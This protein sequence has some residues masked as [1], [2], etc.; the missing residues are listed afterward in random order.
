MNPIKPANNAA[1]TYVPRNTTAKKAA[2]QDIAEKNISANNNAV[3]VKKSKET[4]DGVY[5]SKR[6]A[7]KEKLA[8]I[9]SHINLIRT[10]SAEQL[11]QMIYDLLSMQGRHGAIARGKL[12]AAI[13]GIKSH[14]E[15]GGEIT[16]E[17]QAAAA[18]AI[19]DD[20]PWGVEAV[21]D[22]LVEAAVKFADG[23]ESK[24]NMMKSSIEAGFK[25]AEA[26]WGGTLP[27][28]S[29]RTFEATMT[30]LA[31]AFGQTAETE[32]G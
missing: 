17:E 29:Y 9:S 19:A 18:A 13:L 7:H 5:S 26:V 25:M 11:I 16:A 32:A 1:N 24:F 23:D 27:D 10:Q 14:I 3:N 21:S 28:I 6:A 12:E 4:D 15:S 8:E 20:G 31:A 22:R 2:E 30:K